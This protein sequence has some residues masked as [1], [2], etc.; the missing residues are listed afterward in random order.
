[1]DQRSDGPTVNRPATAGGRSHQPA[2]N[3]LLL[4]RETFELDRAATRRL[5]VQTARPRGNATWDKVDTVVA[6]CQLLRDRLEPDA[7]P[8]V[9]TRPAAHLGGRSLLEAITENHHALVYDV[10]NE[11]LDPW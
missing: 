6:I 4:V 11:V 3:A 1:M 5:M 9:A 10:L 7:I 2:S 8:D